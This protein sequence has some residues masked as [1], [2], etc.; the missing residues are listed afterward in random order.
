MTAI[1]GEVGETVDRRLLDALGGRLLAIAPHLPFTGD[2]GAVLVDR[3]PGPLVQELAASLL[4]E[5]ADA[6]VWLL[7]VGISAAFPTA[8]QVRSA[9]R[10][11][12]RSDGVD[13]FSAILSAATDGSIGSD[14]LDRGIEVIT[15]RMVVDVDFCARHLHNT[16][17]QR[18][19]RQT[20]SRW[21]SDEAHSPV[22]A[23][24]TDGGRSM[25]R[26]TAAELARVVDYQS[27]KDLAPEDERS[28]RGQTNLIVPVGTTVAVVEVPR[29]EICDPLAALAQF[30]GNRTVVIGYDAI[31]VVSADTVPAAETE[32][33]VRYLSL[34]KYVDTVAAISGSVQEEFAGFAHSVSPQG[35]SGPRSIE[36]ALPV[37]LPDA[38]AASDALAPERPLLLCVGSQE[39]RKNHD[40]VL[41]ASE[42]LWRE[43]LDF[44]VRF[45]GRGSLWFTK[46]FDRRIS[47]LSQKGRDVAVLRGIS[48]EEMLS[49]YERARFT[50]FPSLQ[51]GYGLPVAESLALRTP[52]ITTGYGSTGEI[53]RDGGCLTIDP[54][55]DMTL[56]DAMRSLLT[57]DA[58]YTRLV[59]EIDERPRRTWDDYAAELWL[60]F[61][62]DGAL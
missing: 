29:Y 56:V 22:L 3:G 24:W 1:Q 10:A 34:I 53:A 61:T 18:V 49:L 33:F 48:D 12:R 45:V 25:R 40:A 17:I 37:D 19:V 59:T 39:P 9:R 11:L 8:D 7:L 31:P 15:D 23:G 32:R 2:A 57:D 62:S 42:V 41:F 51:E 58:E 6:D 16:G 35:L 38:Q 21:W 52:V 5:P 20:V 27:V 13:A 30:S 55:D 60:A 26:L 28:E 47:A 44:E 43:G 46:G 4:P 54:R 36:V 50:V 14:G